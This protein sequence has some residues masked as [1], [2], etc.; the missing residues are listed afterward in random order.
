[1]FD[2]QHL[3]HVKFVFVWRS[4]GPGHNTPWIWQD[5]TEGIELLLTGGSA[6]TIGSTT[7]QLRPGTMVWHQPGDQTIYR[8]DPEDP[9]HALV[10]IFSTSR[11]A[12]VRAPRLTTWADPDEAV[13]FAG[14]TQS[15]YHG[16]GYDH[17]YLCRHLYS[18][19]WWQVHRAEVAGTTPS[20]PAPIAAV[21]RLIEQHHRQALSI[22]DLADAAGV[23]PTH[24]H[25]LFREHLRTSPLEALIRRRLRTAIA[26]LTHEPHRTVRSVA[27]ACGIPDAVHFGRLF[28]ARHGSTP[29][30]YRRRHAYAPVAGR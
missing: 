30:E 26:L 4:P 18:R 12:A 28:K 3:D 21:L 9:Y 10:V 14:E 25:R 8:V 7:H 1:M 16:G 15:A 24:L 27:E 13:V 6:L 2:D 5:G 19:L 11:P 23:S 20:A 17:R 29:M 22:A